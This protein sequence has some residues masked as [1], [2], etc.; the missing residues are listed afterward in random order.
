M[1][2]TD[3]EYNEI[4]NHGLELAADIARFI[5]DTHHPETSA[6]I[7]A[8]IK[9]KDPI[10]L[11]EVNI[12]LGAMATIAAD[13]CGLMLR[14]GMRTIFCFRGQVDEVWEYS[15]EDEEE[16]SLYKNEEREPEK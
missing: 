4:T 11:N 1:P 16:I 5:P 7:I 3:P 6:N 15:A 8:K 13:D 14:Y 12:L 10:D 9:R 2:K